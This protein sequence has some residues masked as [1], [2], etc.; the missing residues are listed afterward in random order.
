MS[1][2]FLGQPRPRM[3]IVLV[4][5]VDDAAISSAMISLQFGAPDAV[6]V[7]HRI[8]PERSVLTRVVSDLNGIVEQA[9][10][11]LEHVCVPCAIRE[12]IVPTLQRLADQGRWRS[13]IA[14]LPV[15]AD[16]AQV[17]R[18]LGWRPSHARLPSVTGVVAALDGNRIADDLLGDAL[19]DERGLALS[20]EDRRGVAEVACS[21]VEYADAIAFTAAAEPTEWSL[22]RTLA[23]PDASVLADPSLLDADAL[24]GA[25]RSPVAVEEWVAPSR[26]SELPPVADGGAWRIDLRSDLPL[27]PL[28]FRDELAAIGSGPRRSR[29]CFW[30]PTRP[31]EL[32]V[33]DGAGGQVSIG[34]APRGPSGHRMQSRI[35][36]IGIDDDP[37][38]RAAIRAAFARCLVTETELADKGWRWAEGW[39]GF[40]PWLGPIDDVA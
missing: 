11:P 24:L 13:I 27:H 29:G 8:D 14:G 36:V 28:R 22:V 9:E 3:P 18:A 12:D 37:A 33:W 7:R 4:T 25:A 2:E 26:P 1:P 6:A 38:D 23:R 21:L 39:D 17:S 19:L 16:A 35:V 20:A 10:I 5:G 40:E 34:L 31:D 30:L 32:G 15:S